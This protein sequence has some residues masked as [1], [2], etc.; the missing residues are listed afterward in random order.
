MST[1]TTDGHHNKYTLNASDNVSV[2]PIA[3][4][5]HLQLDALA[6][7]L[8]LSRQQQQEEEEAAAAATLTMSDP[9]MSTYSVFDAL[10]ETIYSEVA[11][12][13]ANNESRPH[14]LVELFRELQM[15]TTDYLRQRA[16]YNL[17]DL[18][19]R[20]LTEEG[21]TKE[22]KAAT[23]SSHNV[24]SQHPYLSGF[25]CLGH[26]GEIVLCFVLCQC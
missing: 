19:T 12:L 7:E 8:L 15:L 10:R 23:T 4:P 1:C 9:T 17:Q 26:V 2:H 3:I 13:I 20:Y 18:V 6:G 5:S 24:V 16:L 22:A 25:E 11:T 21:V 14:F